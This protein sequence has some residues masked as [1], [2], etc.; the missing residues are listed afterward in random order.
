M[1]D[2]ATACKS[3]PSNFSDAIW[4]EI[5]M[6][7]IILLIICAHCI[8]DLFITFRTESQDNQRLCFAPGKQY[9]SM[10]SRQKSRLNSDLTYFICFPAITANTFI[11]N[12]SS[13]SF[14][15]TAFDMTLN[16]FFHFRKF[17]N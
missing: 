17:F 8:D 5:V 16:L 6:K 3:N 2:F 4:R 1:S 14:F 10:C 11:Q 9:R 15:E 7:I 13:K 12:L